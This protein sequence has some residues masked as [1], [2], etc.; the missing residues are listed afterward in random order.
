MPLS[1][2]NCNAVAADNGLRAWGSNQFL[3][4]G[5]SNGGVT[6]IPES[7]Y[8]ANRLLVRFRLQYAGQAKDIE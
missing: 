1:E 5:T 8:G 3:Q 4:D 6:G 7:G 2:R